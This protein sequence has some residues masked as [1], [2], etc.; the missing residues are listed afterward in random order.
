MTSEIAPRFTHQSLVLVAVVLQ[1]RKRDTYRFV[2]DVQLVVR[3]QCVSKE[4]HT[5]R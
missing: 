1:V 5:C 2:V 3:Q 4:S